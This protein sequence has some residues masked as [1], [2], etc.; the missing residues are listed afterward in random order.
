MRYKK[1][2]SVSEV[3]PIESCRLWREEGWIKEVPDDCLFH[4]AGEDGVIEIGW[5]SVLRGGRK[6]R[7]WLDGG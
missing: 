1:F 2:L 3:G 5:I 4:D 6:F 7:D